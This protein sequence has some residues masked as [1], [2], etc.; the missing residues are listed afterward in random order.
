MC[1]HDDEIESVRPGELSDLCRCVA[2][3]QDSRALKQR[4]LRVEERIEFIS[5]EV[6]LFFGNLGRRPYVELESVMT[7]KIEDVS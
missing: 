6:T 3:Q 1:G 2:R 5:S 4:K 7:V